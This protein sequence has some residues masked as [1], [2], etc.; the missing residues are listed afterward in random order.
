LNNRARRAVGRPG[1]A[2]P[3]PRLR[4]LLQQLARRALRRRRRRERRA[5][6]ADARAVA[7]RRRL[8]GL[9]R[10]RRHVILAEAGDGRVS[11]VRGGRTVVAGVPERARPVALRGGGD[12]ETLT[13]FFIASTEASKSS[14][15]RAR[16]RE[17]K[18]AASSGG[19]GTRR[20]RGDRTP[21]PAETRSRAFA[22]RDWARS[23]ERARGARGDRGRRRHR[24]R[25][26]PCGTGKKREHAEETGKTRRGERE[27]EALWKAREDG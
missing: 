2:F 14:A 21:S 18:S 24:P 5:V 15:R 6:G 8:L 27:G 23:R 25:A 1:G 17:R 4:G 3:Y 19:P 10:F 20:R 22:V 12:D 7:R 11:A 13:A 9:G 26:S 16:A